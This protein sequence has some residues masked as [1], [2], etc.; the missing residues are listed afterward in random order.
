MNEFDTVL[1]IMSYRLKTRRPTNVE[2][3]FG[4][5]GISC[6]KIEIGLLAHNWV[7]TVDS[8]ETAA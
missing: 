3:I 5:V 8:W 2:I 6:C 7:I 4:K 1:K